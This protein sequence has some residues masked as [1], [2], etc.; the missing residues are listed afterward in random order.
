MKTNL[1][2]Q[3]D[4]SADGPAGWNFSGT[5]DIWTAA[6]RNAFEDALLGYLA[7]RIPGK[8]DI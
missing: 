5:A 4:V 3:G 7:V 8:R 1:Y 2:E 6:H